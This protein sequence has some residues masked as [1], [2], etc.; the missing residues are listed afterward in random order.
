MHFE[1][2]A[3]KFSQQLSYNGAKIY[4]EYVKLKCEFQGYESPLFL[5]NFGYQASVELSDDRMNYL[6]LRSPK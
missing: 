2:L 3:D 4:N 1:P 5:N 6:M